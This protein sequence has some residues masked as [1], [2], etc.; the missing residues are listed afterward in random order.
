M[1][2]FSSDIQICL[3][4]CMNDWEAIL[5]MQE[6]GDTDESF[7][8]NKIIILLRLRISGPEPQAN[9][10]NVSNTNLRK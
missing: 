6:N 1:Y 7:H 5:Q 8:L 9:F 10:L 3:H 2:D 4:L